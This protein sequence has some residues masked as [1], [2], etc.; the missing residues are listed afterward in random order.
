MEL[1]PSVAMNESILIFTTRKPL[2][3]PTTRPT[4]SAAAMEAGTDHWASIIAQPAVTDAAEMVAPIDRSNTPADSGTSRPSAMTIKM[5]FEF[6]TE[7]WVSHI[8]QVSGIHRVN[9][10]QMRA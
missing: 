9:T 6:S 4:S 2:R 3:L 10:T 7:R 5:A 1:T 8:V